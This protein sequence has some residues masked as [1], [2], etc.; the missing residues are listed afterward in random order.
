MWSCKCTDLQTS[1]R[2]RCIFAIILQGVVLP[3]VLIV[4]AISAASVPATND[5]ETVNDVGSWWPYLLT[6]PA[7]LDVVLVA[8]V[9]Y[10]ERGPGGSLEYQ[11]FP[12]FPSGQLPGLPSP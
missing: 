12:C 10:R 3:I 11:L 8:M 4:L 1:S 5:A 9:I 7:F 2:A 6:L